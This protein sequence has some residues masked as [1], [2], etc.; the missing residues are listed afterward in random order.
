MLM[1]IWLKDMKT[2]PR[3]DCCRSPGIVLGT[4]CEAM[5]QIP[6]T[7]H[8]HTSFRIQRVRDRTGMEKPIQVLA[9]ISEE[10][11]KFRTAVR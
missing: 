2:L 8:S 6:Q 7:T 11:G 10:W 1:N 4:E 3:V 5:V 9:D